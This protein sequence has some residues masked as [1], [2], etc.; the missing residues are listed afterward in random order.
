MNTFRIYFR[1]CSNLIG[2][3]NTLVQVVLYGISG[4]KRMMISER[5]R[6][7]MIANTINE[8]NDNK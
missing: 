8:H 3:W 2:F 6:I 4:F 7:A 5:F 1:Y